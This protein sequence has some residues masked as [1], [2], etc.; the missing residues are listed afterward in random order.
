MALVQIEE[1]EL[2]QLK[3][4]AQTPKGRWWRLPDFCKHMNV[5]RYTVH[6]LNKYLTEKHGVPLTRPR[7]II[8]IQVDTQT[9]NKYYQ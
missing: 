5:S 2:Q 7:K 6:R 4:A 8:G 1:R 3:E 9:Y